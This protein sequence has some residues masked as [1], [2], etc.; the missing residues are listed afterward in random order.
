MLNRSM[1]ELIDYTGTRREP[2]TFDNWREHQK[3]VIALVFPAI[4]KRQLHLSQKTRDYLNNTRRKLLTADL[5]NGMPVYIVD[6]QY[7]KGS[8]RPREAQRNLGEFKIVRRLFNGPY[9]IRD[10]TGSERRVPIDQL[11]FTRGDIREGTKERDDNVYEVKELLD[12]RINEETGGIEYLVWWKGYP[13][14]D[15][16]WQPIENIH[17]TALIR[18]YNK[19]KKTTIARIQIMRAAGH[20]SSLD[21]RLQSPKLD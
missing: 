2:V 3:E 7:V 19:R 20:P 8:P 13:K 15:A 11:V 10:A 16:D 4:E 6:P 12:D 18:N 17:H 5:P 14:S 9:L 1:N 21:L